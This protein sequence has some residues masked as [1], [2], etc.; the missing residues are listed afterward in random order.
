MKSDISIHFYMKEPYQQ[1]YVA[2]DNCPDGYQNITDSADCETASTYL[3]LAYSEDQNTGHADAICNLCASCNETNGGASTRLDE[4]HGN[5][6]R[7][8][9]KLSGKYVPYITFHQQ[10]IIIKTAF[11]QFIVNLSQ[12]SE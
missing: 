5:L 6:A 1:G 10:Q 3:G 9:C 7:W 11:D 2:T 12:C 4:Q 8:I